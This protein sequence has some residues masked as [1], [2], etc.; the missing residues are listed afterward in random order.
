MQVVVER[1]SKLYVQ[2]HKTV[3]ILS[4]SAWS[5]KDQRKS[6]GSN[7]A[8]SQVVST[9]KLLC[10]LKASATLT[11]IQIACLKYKH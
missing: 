2:L 8:A 10:L 1:L 6:S 11:E 4:Y 3:L 5:F 7:N 9:T